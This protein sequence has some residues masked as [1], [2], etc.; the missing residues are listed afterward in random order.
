MK[1]LKKLD[2]PF[3]I[4]LF[5]T[6]F[7]H[8]C[9]CI[10]DLTICSYTIE[11]ILF[12]YF[13]GSYI[14]L[15][16]GIFCECVLN[17]FLYVGFD[18]SSYFLRIYAG[19]PVFVDQTE[20]VVHIRK[21]SFFCCLGLYKWKWKDVNIFSMDFLIDF[22]HFCS[23]FVILNDQSTKFWEPRKFICKSH[24]G[25][26]FKMFNK[27]SIHTLDFRLLKPFQQSKINHRQYFFNKII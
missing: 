17:D 7:A 6:Y 14:I 4:N 9:I 23:D 8:V 21:G 10:Y 20:N 11:V 27:I 12:G 15:N 13:E 2:F 25:V 3:L 22:D 5:T 16:Q 18:L 19:N 1:H 24:V 26:N